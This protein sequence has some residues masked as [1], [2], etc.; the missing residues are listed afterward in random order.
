MVA[1]SQELVKISKISFAVQEWGLKTPLNTQT[2][3][4]ATPLR[5]WTTCESPLRNKWS[6]TS[7][8]ANAI[9]RGYTL[10]YGIMEEQSSQAF[11]QGTYKHQSLV[12]VINTEREQLDIYATSGT[13]GLS[14]HHLKG[15][16]VTPCRDK[17]TREVSACSDSVHLI[18]SDIMIYGV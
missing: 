14:F 16:S 13:A 7:I 1:D 12:T 11:P 15:N 6:L 3:T 9:N 8:L 10:E 2:F 5:L 18:W 17:Q 4:D